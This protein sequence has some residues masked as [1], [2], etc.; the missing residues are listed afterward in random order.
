MAHA[1]AQSSVCVDKDSHSATMWTPM[2]EEKKEVRL[3]REGWLEFY[4]YHLGNGET[5]RKGRKWGLPFKYHV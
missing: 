2:H 3:Q 1:S 5:L 4:G